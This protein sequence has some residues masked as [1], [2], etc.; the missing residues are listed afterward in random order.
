M[1]IGLIDVDGHNKMW[2]FK[3]C[4]FADFEP[5]KGFKCKEYLNN[6]ELKN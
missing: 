4:D 3:T 6:Y 5:R 1:K 2:I